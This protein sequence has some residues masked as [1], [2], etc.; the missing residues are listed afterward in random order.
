MDLCSEYEI[1]LATHEDYTE[2]ATFLN[3]RAMSF[4]KT[5]MRVVRVDGTFR[6]S[7]INDRRTT[8]VYFIRRKSAGDIVGFCVSTLQDTASI[9]PKGFLG[10]L[11]I[12]EDCRRGGLANTI[13][14]HQISELHREFGCVCIEAKID[15]DN[16]ASRSLVRKLGFL[17]VEGHARRFRLTY[18]P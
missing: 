4:M 17:P 3:L 1:V 14:Q 16:M 13:I 10:W 2:I 11:F 18:T 15:K 7:R 6:F 8:R 5:S 12:D 9:P